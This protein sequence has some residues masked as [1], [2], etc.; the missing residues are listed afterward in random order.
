MAK[1]VEEQISIASEKATKAEKKAVIALIKEKV[2]ALEGEKEVVK[3]VKT[4]AKE[5]VEAIKA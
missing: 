4:F 5:L 2:G 1:S 3:A